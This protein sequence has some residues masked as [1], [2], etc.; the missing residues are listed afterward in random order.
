LF[1]HFDFVEAGTQNAHGFFAVFG[2][3][4]F[5][6]ATDDGVGRDVRDTHGGGRGVDRLAAWAR[7]AEGVDAQIF[8]FDFDVDV[9]G[10]GKHG[11]GHSGG[12]DAALLFGRGHALDTMHSAFVLELGKYALTFDDGDD[13]FEA[14]DG[15]F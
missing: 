9:F 2:L 15:G 1:L 8:G 4:L 10:F 3:R 5:V 12:V 11:D 7:G 6:L 13:F 14:T